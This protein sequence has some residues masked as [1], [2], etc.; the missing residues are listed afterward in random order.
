[1]DDAAA[2]AATRAAFLTLLEAPDP[3]LLGWLTGRSRPEDETVARLVDG[4]RGLS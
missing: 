1:M 4:I 2:D 3:Q